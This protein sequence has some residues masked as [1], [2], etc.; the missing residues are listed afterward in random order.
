MKL[1]YYM[2]RQ[3]DSLIDN[4]KE[5]KAKGKTSITGNSMNDTYLA[6]DKILKELPGNPLDNYKIPEKLIYISCPFGHSNEHIVENRVN[7]ANSYY[8]QLLKGNQNAISPLTIGNV[9]RTYMPEHQWDSKFWMPIDLHLLEKCDEMH[10]LC[11]AGWRNSK[12]VKEEIDFCERK[13]IP[14]KYISIVEQREGDWDYAK[15][16]FQF[17]MNDNV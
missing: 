13:G 6:I 3:W 16:S 10:V 1:P 11:L 2:Q 17:V 5:D 8:V 7:F 4:C 14:I 15:E 12:G 9:L